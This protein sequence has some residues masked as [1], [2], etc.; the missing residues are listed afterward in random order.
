[1]I[2][3]IRDTL[4]FCSIIGVLVGITWTADI[5]ERYRPAYKAFPSISGP[6]TLLAVSLVTIGICSFSEW[7]EQR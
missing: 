4:I 5:V 6:V 2:K 7:L 1:M 3:H